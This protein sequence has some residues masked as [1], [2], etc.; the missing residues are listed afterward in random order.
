MSDQWNEHKTKRQ[1]YCVFALL[2]CRIL[3]AYLPGVEVHRGPLSHSL[4]VE[5]DPDPFPSLIVSVLEET[6]TWKEKK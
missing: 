3:T 5:L 2:G 6:A 4:Q 1:L